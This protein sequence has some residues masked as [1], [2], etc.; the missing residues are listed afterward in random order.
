MRLASIFLVT[1]A[2]LIAHSI[3]YAAPGDSNIYVHYKTKAV[4]V[5]PL[6]ATVG[7][8]VDIKIILRANGTVED[9][10]D[11]KGGIKGSSKNKLGGRGFKVVNSSTLL[12]SGKAENYTHKTTIKVDGKNCTASVER[13]L[14]P[15]EKEYREF[16]KPLKQVAFYSSIENEYTTCVIE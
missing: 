2:T 10:Y 13:I 7:T 3:A 4:R 12:R 8:T 14:N 6:P 1:C 16:S 5:R 11:V 15:G 9:A